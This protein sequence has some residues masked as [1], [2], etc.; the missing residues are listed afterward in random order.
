[1]LKISKMRKSTGEAESDKHI[2]LRTEITIH[3]PRVFSTKSQDF[4]SM[5]LKPVIEA[6]LF[7]KGSE[8]SKDKN[9]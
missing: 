9:V 1:M 8:S 6:Q 5:F 3:P 7:L 4:T 2:H